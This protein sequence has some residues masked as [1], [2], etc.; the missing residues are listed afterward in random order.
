MLD[1][2]SGTPGTQEWNSVSGVEELSLSFLQSDASLT[3]S[4]GLQEEHEAEMLR[5]AGSCKQ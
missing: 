4:H 3:F 5:R 1:H 2:H